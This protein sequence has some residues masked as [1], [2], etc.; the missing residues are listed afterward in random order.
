MYRSHFIFFMS[1]EFTF[2]ITQAV[3]LL[4][5]NQKLNWQLIGLKFHFDT[6]HIQNF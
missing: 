4:N 2:N 5:K 3:T 1:N 6:T